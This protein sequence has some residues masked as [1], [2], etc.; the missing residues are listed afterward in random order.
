MQA[1]EPVACEPESSGALDPSVIR[2]WLVRTCTAQGLPVTIT[3]PAAVAQLAV[4][5]APSTPIVAGAS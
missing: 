5:F 4:L 3:D 2:R 1:T